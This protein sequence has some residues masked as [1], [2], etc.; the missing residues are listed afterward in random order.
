MRPNRTTDFDNRKL[1]PLATDIQS[2]QNENFL[3][4]EEKSIMTKSKIIHNQSDSEYYFEERCF[5]T[6]WWNSPM[7]KEVSI[8]RARLESGITTRLH[9]L[10]DVTERYI[11]LEGKGRVEV[12]N[13][14]AANI[15]PG[16][17][18]LIPPGT[19]QRI[20][21]I[22]DSDLIFLAVCTPRFTKNAY[23]DIDST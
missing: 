20:T 1:T 2:H 9:R 18:V 10:K 6:E 19:P 3:A 5:I 4:P 17:V 12:G 7:D 23:E 21:N 16:D 14:L 8:A 22:G 15:G 11:I 13:L